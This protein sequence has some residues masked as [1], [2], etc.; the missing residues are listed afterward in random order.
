M[1]YVPARP[2]ELTALQGNEIMIGTLR[3]RLQLLQICFTALMMAGACFPDSLSAKALIQ[4]QTT[5]HHL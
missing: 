4:Q 3:L 1:W 5:A 2:V